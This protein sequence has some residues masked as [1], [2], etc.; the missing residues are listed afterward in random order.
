TANKSID[1]QFYVTT[2]MHRYETLKR[3]IDFNPGIYGIIFTRTKMDAQEISERLTREGYD[4]DA[5]HGDL[6]QAQRDKVMGQ[7]R[8]KSL[9]LLIATDV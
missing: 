8:D 4:I 7:F 6:T 2:A 9:Q 5:L 3:I 1:H